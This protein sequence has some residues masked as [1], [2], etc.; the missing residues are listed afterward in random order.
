MLTGH[1]RLNS[2]VQ[3]QQVRLVSDIF[4]NTNDLTNLIRA[5]TQTFNLLRGFLHIFADQHH[6]LDRLANGVL[7][8]FRV[9]QSFLG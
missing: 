8:G 1:G 7:T 2:G 3:R 5:L 6:T 9:L 4:N